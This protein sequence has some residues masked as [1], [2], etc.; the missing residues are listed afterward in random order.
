MTQGAKRSSRAAPAPTDPG[1]PPPDPIR[2]PHPGTDRKVSHSQPPS[3]PEVPSGK[4]QENI[5]KAHFTLAIP[6]ELVT[7]WETNDFGID[8]MVEL[9]Y[10]QDLGRKF[11]ASGKKFSAQ[12]KS[13]ASRAGTSGV[14]TLSV[15]VQKVIYWLSCSEPVMLVRHDSTTGE[16]RFVWID[17]GFAA[18]VTRQR[19]GWQTGR[20]ITVYFRLGDRLTPDR[21]TQIEGY[22][23]R[24]RPPGR[25]P[26][27]PSQFFELREGMRRLTSDLARVADSVGIV[28]LAAPIDELAHRVAQ[29][30]YSIAITGPSRV[31]KSTLINALVRREI[32]P[33]GLLPTTGLPVVLIG[34][35]TPIAT[36]TFKDGTSKSVE[37]TSAG[38]EPYV[39]QDQ[40]RGNAKGVRLVTVAIPDPGLANGVSFLDIPGLDDPDPAIGA[41]SALVV[42]GANAIIYVIDASPFEHGGFAFN[43]HH[44]EDLRRISSSADRVFLLLNKADALSLDKRAPLLEY[45]KA[46]LARFN[47]ASLLPNEPQL[48]SAQH[49]W[50]ARTTGAPGGDPLASFESELWGFILGKSK[51]GIY[52]LRAAAQEAVDRIPDALRLVEAE[53]S[54]AQSRSDLEAT[55]TTG[56]ARY[57]Q[58]RP[59]LTA[60]RDQSWWM[61]DRQLADSKQAILGRLTQVIDSIPVGGA[62]PS[63]D[64]IR[65]YLE[66][67]AASALAEG[68]KGVSTAL[69]RIQQTAARTVEL[70]F[71][72]PAAQRGQALGKPLL[73]VDLSAAAVPIPEDL[74][75]PIFTAAI[76]G[77]AGLALGPLGA[78]AGL[79]VGFFAGLFV[80]AQTRH[81][82]RANALVANANKALQ[83]AFEEI[84]RGLWRVLASGTDRI[85]R[86]ADD[87]AQVFA[88]D[89]KGR[90]AALGVAMSPE[91]RQALEAAKADFPRLLTQ[92]RAQVAEL[93]RFVF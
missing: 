17:E 40:N 58:S 30:A 36:V 92:A 81:Q 50:I 82:R 85:I 53:L 22:V 20:T 33:V 42:A 80:S 93:E 26:L 32:S 62:L 43:I 59:S 73:T 83:G 24:W 68:G 76:G 52:L 86:W 23:L 49:A 29:S 18:N 38:L 71:S 25:Q 45:V 35:A 70:A 12:I 13:R 34:G 61:I 21:Q 5:S 44:V 67:H 75:S 39:T 90:A 63:P 56:L 66:T 31:G 10:S 72:Q 48:L 47:L 9:T 7:K 2:P 27:S 46:Q 54:Q 6:Q 57:S 51:A 77:L 91:R 64:E 16:L 37:P 78:L 89:L 88:G 14:L 69:G 28:T 41:A 3:L 65:S 8:A 4:L 55:M 19:P 74:S 87:R 84:R 1:L 60:L 15:D 79:V 11:V